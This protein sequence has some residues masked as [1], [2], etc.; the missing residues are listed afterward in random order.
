MDAQLF[1]KTQSICKEPFQTLIKQLQEQGLISS[2]SY[3]SDFL[4]EKLLESVD[5]MVDE[6]LKSSE[7]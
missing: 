4:Y 5:V 3:N 7:G 2:D 1:A 6:H